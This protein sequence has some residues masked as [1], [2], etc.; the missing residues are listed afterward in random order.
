MAKLPSGT[1]SSDDSGDLG[2][3]FPAS[4]ATPQKATPPK[5]PARPAEPVQRASDG[6]PSWMGDADPSLAP[7]PPP[8]AAKPPKPAAAPKPALASRPV[9]QKAAPPRS[10]P[11]ARPAAAA[12]APAPAP[13]PR[14][15]RRWL[16]SLIGAFVV[17]LALVAGDLAA[18]SR[19][20]AAIKFQQIVA[21]ALGHLPAS[22]PPI[23]PFAAGLALFLFGIAVWQAGRPRRP[24][25]LPILLV[26]CLT[27]AAIGLF[28]GGR[29]VDI[30]RSAALFKGR[31]GSLERELGRMRKDFAEWQ[32]TA[33]KQMADKEQ[34]MASALEGVER[35]LREETA[36]LQE[37]QAE[38][39]KMAGSLHSSTIAHQAALKEKDDVLS[40]LRKELEDL[41][42]KLA[43]K[44]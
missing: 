38:R 34:A 39:D 27:S 6:W 37:A 23:L 10:V 25:F 26:L 11:A 16:R 18:R 24:L 44:N 35:K 30:E 29:D 41:K 22:F 9:E 43:E 40:A 8:P 42:K 17:L 32:K 19:P 12:P 28:R 15:P 33:S 5:K 14:A 1:P 3:L 4:D 7:A 13:T 31:V 20:E 21:D 36:R 2:D